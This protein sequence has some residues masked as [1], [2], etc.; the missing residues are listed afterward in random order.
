MNTKKILLL[1]AIILV[2]VGGILAAVA[3]GLGAS[4]SITWNRGFRAAQPSNVRYELNETFSPFTRVEL[5][6][7]VS[8]NV[9]LRAGDDYRIEGHHY[10]EITY[11]V[12]GNTLYVDTPSQTRRQFSIFSGWNSLTQGGNVIITVPWETTLYDSNLTLGVGNLRIDNVAFNNAV[13][14]S[15]VG[16]INTQSTDF[17]NVTITAGVG[18]IDA[19]GL[20]SGRADI[21]NGVGDT[22]LEIA[23]PQDR[24]SYTIEGGVG[25]ITIN[26]ERQGGALG[27]T[28]TNTAADP[29]GTLR[30]EAGV[31]SVR[32]DFL[33]RQ[34]RG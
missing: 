5:S 20:F 12:R 14:T 1:I 18:N 3:W 15:G 11:E 13:V 34:T 32:I 28:L 29:L 4:T 10:G 22:T 30:I 19:A 9:T 27:N 23:G 16:D 17:Q 24:F 33:E 25:S 26:G 6:I 21:T 7:G 31:G 2:V 8:N